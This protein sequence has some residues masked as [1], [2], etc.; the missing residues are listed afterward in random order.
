[1]YKNSDLVTTELLN[2]ENQSNGIHTSR[3]NVYNEGQP[4]HQDMYMMKTKSKEENKSKEKIEYSQK[5]VQRRKDIA[6]KHYTVEQ[7][8]SEQKACSEEHTRD[9]RKGIDNKLNEF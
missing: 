6:Q 9:Q 4:C 5:Q 2:N 3:R 8:Y 7:V 1:M